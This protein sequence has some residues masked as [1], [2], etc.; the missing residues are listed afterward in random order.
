MTRSG[1]GM[2]AKLQCSPLAENL[3]NTEILSSQGVFT[4]QSVEFLQNEVSSFWTPHIFEKLWSLLLLLPSSVLLQQQYQC[5]L[6]LLQSKVVANTAERKFLQC[7]RREEVL[8][9]IQCRST[10]SGLVT[11]SIIFCW[12]FTIRD[13]C[14]KVGALS[15]KSPSRVR[16]GDEGVA[17]RNYR[18]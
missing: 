9:F 1:R 17:V 13:V 11:N 8:F 7:K 4:L 2:M 15:S 14:K 6:S 16:D 5:P 12:L 18:K 3:H 10:T